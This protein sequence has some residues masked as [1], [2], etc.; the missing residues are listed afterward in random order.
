MG[1]LW[2]PV[3]SLFR[4][5]VFFSNDGPGVDWVNSMIWK[6]EEEQPLIEEKEGEILPKENLDQYTF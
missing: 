6:D 2:Q 1:S 4:D 5:S 3:R